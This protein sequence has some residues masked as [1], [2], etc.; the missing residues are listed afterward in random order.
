MFGG[1]EGWQVVAPKRLLTSQTTSF[2]VTTVILAV[3]GLV[4]GLVIFFPYGIYNFKCAQFDMPEYEKIFGFELGQVEA[5]DGQ[6]GSYAIS[7]IKAVTSGGVFARSGIRPGDYPRMHHGLVDFCGDL[8]A[9]TEGRTVDLRVR[10]LLDARGAHDG[11]REVR[12]LL[13]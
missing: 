8:H 5:T 1:Q 7:A 2:A 10:N 4:C 3:L 11:W 6:R 9:A 12:L 13:R